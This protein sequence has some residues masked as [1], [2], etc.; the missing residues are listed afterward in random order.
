MPRF[1]IPVIVK[2]HG[3]VEIEAANFDEALDK[4]DEKKFIDD[5]KDSD[6]VGIEVDPNRTYFE[7]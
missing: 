1:I 4:F 2:K 5:S 3:H 6:I 7:L